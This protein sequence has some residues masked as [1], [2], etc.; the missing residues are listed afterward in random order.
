[1]GRGEALMSEKLPGPGKA[2]KQRPQTLVRDN[3][4]TLVLDK[5]GIPGRASGQSLVLLGKRQK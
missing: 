1:M 2:G 5:A 4:R 3:S